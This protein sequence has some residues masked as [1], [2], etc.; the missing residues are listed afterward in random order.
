V[1]RITLSDRKL[2]VTKNGNREERLLE[3]ECQVYAALRDHFGVE[4]QEEPWT[5]AH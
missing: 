4:L 2:I 1:G 3:S 5:Q